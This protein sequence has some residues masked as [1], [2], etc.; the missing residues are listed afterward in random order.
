MP[1][2]DVTDI[3][4]DTDVAAQTF[5]VL[6]RQEIVNQYGE[7]TVLASNANAIGSVQPKGDQS[8]IRED[9]FDAQADSIVVV[10]TYRLRGVTK[11]PSNTQYKPDIIIWQNNYYEVISPNN[12]SQ[13]GTGFIEVE[14]TSIHNV[15]GP[16]GSLPPY[17]GQLVFTNPA[18]SSLAHG[19]SGGI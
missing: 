19:V 8:L 3:L 17:V 10:T 16:P 9:G 14:A 6:R 11:G 13:F 5:V 18:N 1:T 15:D 2:V 7:S 12:W 4:I